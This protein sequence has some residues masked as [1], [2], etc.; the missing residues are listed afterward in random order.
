[1]CVCMVC[2]CVCSCVCVC[3]FMC[4][5]MHDIVHVCLCACVCMYTYV[6]VLHMSCDREMDLSTPS[7]HVYTMDRLQQWAL[8][9]WREA[10]N[11]EKISKTVTDLVR[12]YI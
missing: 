10:K 8:K 4:M 3:V 11:V 6:R 12:S 9:K 5:C 1:M 2:V 7:L